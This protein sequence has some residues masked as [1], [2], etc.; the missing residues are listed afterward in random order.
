[1]KILSG[2]IGGTKT[3]LALFEAD[4]KGLQLCE[5]KSFKSRSFGSLEEI[6]EAFIRSKALTCDRACFGIAGPVKEGVAQT[7]NLLHQKEDT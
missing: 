2:D 5:E 7:T 6:V 4:G 1:M 3:R